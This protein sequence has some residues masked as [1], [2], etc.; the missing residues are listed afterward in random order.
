MEPPDANVPAPGPKPIVGMI[1]VG[2]L[3]GTPG[4]GQTMREIVR[5]ACE[6]ARLYEDNGI[7]CLMIENMHD[8][9]YLRGGV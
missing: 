7:N 3:P 5:L 1:H 8:V 6:E 2:A 4:H 9:P